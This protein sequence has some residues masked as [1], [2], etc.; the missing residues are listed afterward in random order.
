MKNLHNLG[1]MQWWEGDVRALPM[2]VHCCHQG[3]TQFFPPTLEWTGVFV[4]SWGMPHHPAR[5]GPSCLSSFLWSLDHEAGDYFYNAFSEISPPEDL[6]S[7]QSSNTP[8]TELCIISIPQMQKLRGSDTCDTQIT[9]LVRS[10]VRISE[11]L[12][13]T[14]G[15]LFIIM[16]KDAA[17]LVSHK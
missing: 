9:Q 16:W 14:P 4:Y 13:L 6:L 11:R 12:C 10:K 7:H 5:K 15:P 8:W 1:T 3:K 17:S 2:R